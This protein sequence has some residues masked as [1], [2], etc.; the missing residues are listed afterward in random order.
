MIRPA[1]R[2]T[3]FALYQFT[4]AVGILLMPLAVAT[5]KLGVSLPLHRLVETLGE[6]YEGASAA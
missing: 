6:A 1:Y 2:K 4:V 5:R 3:V